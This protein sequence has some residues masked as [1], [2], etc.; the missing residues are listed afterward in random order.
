[1]YGI[2]QTW[3]SKLNT[4]KMAFELSNEGVNMKFIC[5]Q[6]NNK[7]YYRLS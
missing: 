1:M 2:A 7:M 3:P 4:I 6:L 5:I